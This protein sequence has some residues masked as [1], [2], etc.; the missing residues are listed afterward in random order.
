MKD[1]GFRLKICHKELINQS[2]EILSERRLFR[3]LLSEEKLR[4]EVQLN[5]FL[6]ENSNVVQFKMQEKFDKI[7]KYKDEQLKRQEC[8]I[9]VLK[10]QQ[11]AIYNQF[12][13]LAENKSKVTVHYKVIIFNY[14]H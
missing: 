7:V 6:R 4:S 8:L 13:K 3:E 9:S 5:S 1:N 12:H 10:K 2:K 14:C 11:E